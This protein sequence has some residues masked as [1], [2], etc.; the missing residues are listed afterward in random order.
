MAAR[1]SLPDMLL[2]VGSTL[3]AWMVIYAHLL[4]LA[5]LPEAGCSD[6]DELWR[7][8][9]GFA[10]IAAAFSLLLRAV[11]VL[12]GIYA[13]TRFMAIPAGLLILLAI[14]PV[15]AALNAA[16]LASEPLCPG[17][18]HAAWQPYWAPVQIA[19]L[20]IIAVQ[21]LRAWRLPGSASAEL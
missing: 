17:L 10:P 6:G 18:T 7:L 2:R 12:P 1:G 5:I 11:H 19:T 8:L 4:W 9:L 16:T 14:Q 21:S 20:L 15:I 13:I 3:V